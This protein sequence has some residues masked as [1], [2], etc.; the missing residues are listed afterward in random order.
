MTPRKERIPEW[1]SG[2][3]SDYVGTP[4]QVRGGI[5]SAAYK[6]YIGLMAMESLSQPEIFYGH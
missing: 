4:R 6:Y 2:S 5:S 1:K 3:A